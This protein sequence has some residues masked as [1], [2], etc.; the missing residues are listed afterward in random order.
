MILGEEEKFSHI[1]M[2]NDHI[3]NQI[4]LY[5]NPYKKNYNECIKDL[6]TH[7]IYNACMRQLRSFTV[8]YQT[9][10]VDDN[11][12]NIQRRNYFQKNAILYV[13]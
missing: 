3:Q 2:M 8:T 1:I 4:F 11:N 10:D 13:S 7:E 12:T 9:I 6:R 5:H